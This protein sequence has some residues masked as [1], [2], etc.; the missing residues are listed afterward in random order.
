MIF[1]VRISVA[2]WLT[3]CALAYSADSPCRV[4]M[5]DIEGPYYIQGAPEKNDSILCDIKESG[6]GTKFIVKGRVTQDDCRTGIQALLD[7]WSANA[8]G[9]YALSPG[10]YRCRGI[11]TT[12]P[13]GYYQI[14]TVLPGWYL[15]GDSYRPA[16]IHWKIT[17]LDR[18]DETLTTQLYFEHDPYLADKDPCHN[19]GCHSGDPTLTV[20][21]NRSV[22]DKNTFS[23]EWNIVLRQQ[24]TEEESDNLKK[25]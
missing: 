21:L 25:H 2:V 11:F 6:N 1:D 15:T 24:K 16:H 5:A 13:E 9:E 7:V 3:L 4:T 23:A 12:D 14:D 20:P 22:S 18:P 19:T 8:F 17:S 10:D